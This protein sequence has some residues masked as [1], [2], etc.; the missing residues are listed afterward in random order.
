MQSKSYIR[1]ILNAAR[2]LL[3]SLPV[4]EKREPNTKGLS[5]WV[6]EQTVR[7]CLS[8]E[9]ITLGLCPTIE[10]QVPLYGR[11]KIDLLVGRVA[12]EIKALGFFGDDARKYS[13]YRAK[14]EE[15]GS[16]VKVNFMFFLTLHRNSDI[17]RKIG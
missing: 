9:L 14:V 12:I 16:Y 15:I 4:A 13:R 11:T 2:Q 3:A 10:E 7:H 5:G 6:Y 17:L 8:E 1:R